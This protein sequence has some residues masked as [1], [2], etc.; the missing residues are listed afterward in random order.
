MQF[1]QATTSSSLVSGFCNDIHRL[2]FRDDSHPS[3]DIFSPDKRQYV[4]FFWFLSFSQRSLTHTS[5]LKSSIIYF[6][7]LFAKLE[8]FCRNFVIKDK[9]MSLRILLRLG[10]GFWSLV[11]LY[12]AGL[13][14]GLLGRTLHHRCG[15][16]F[17]KF[18]VDGYSIVIKSWCL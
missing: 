7:S 5:S 18:L 1:I 13:R 4:S 12:G 3:I 6:R 16:E 2:L 15:S 9:E 8:P 14:H 17:A 11:F 10:P